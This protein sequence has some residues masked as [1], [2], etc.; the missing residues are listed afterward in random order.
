M[1]DTYNVAMGCKGSAKIKP[2]LG[3]G[4]VG[5]GRYCRRWRG[6]EVGS[7]GRAKPGTP[8]DVLHRDN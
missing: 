5:E 1:T 6:G 8:T 4:E 3:E 7:G 2:G